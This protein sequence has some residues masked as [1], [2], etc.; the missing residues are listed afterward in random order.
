MPDPGASDANNAGAPET[1]RSATSASI[2]EHNPLALEEI[3]RSIFQLAEP[4]SLAVAARVCQ[5]WSGIALDE[6][7]RSLPSIYPLLTL[8]VPRKWIQDATKYHKDILDS[9]VKADWDRFKGY[10]ARIRFVNADY[11]GEVNLPLDSVALVQT[12]HGPSP[13]LPNVKTISWS[14]FQ[15]KNFMNI[16]P[17]IGP[18]LENLDLEMEEGINNPEQAQL[19]QSLTR[20]TP[21][22]RS[23]GLTSFNKVQHI[24]TPLTALISSSPKLVRL[25]LPTFFLTKEVVAAAANLPFLRKLLYSA[26]P[27]AQN[28][29]QESGMCFEFTPES[30]PQ[31]ETLAFAA[32]PTRMAEVLD[33]TDHV[34]RLRWVYLDCPAYYSSQDIET[35]FAKLA[36]GGKCLHTVQ[37]MCCAVRPLAGSSSHDSLSIDTIR[38]LFSCT[39]LGTFLLWA[40]HFVPL[41]EED[42]VEMGK[43]WPLMHSLTLCP[44]PISKKDQ[45]TGFNI[46]AAFAKS[47]PHLRILRLFFNKEIPIFDGDLYPVSQ[48]TRLERLRVGWSPVPKGKAQEIG[49]LLASLCQRPPL[50]DHGTTEND[51]GNDITEEQKTTL[52]AGWFDVKA[53]VNLAF[54]VKSSFTCKYGRMMESNAELEQEAS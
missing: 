27:E 54:R 37:L 39:R 25:K 21:N 38:P 47:L 49:F 33:A 40:P 2:V 23:L 30:F 22:L 7:W 51:R 14:F 45:G 48:F 17:F 52:A 10:A 41:D 6:L 19:V 12:F 3:L 20:R 43:N 31:L 32:L 26:W 44:T 28:I 35:V 11:N 15:N 50:I 13:L 53:A 16:I 4:P 29:Y 34:G 1:D 36:A 42:V 5:R 18:Q 24:G 46:L 8:L 9:L